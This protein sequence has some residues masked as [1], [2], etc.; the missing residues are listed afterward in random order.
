MT[1]QKKNIFL[2]SA[3]VFLFFNRIGLP[4]G[5]LYTT[6]LAPLFLLFLLNSKGIIPYFLFLLVSGVFALAHFSV[7]MVNELAYFRSFLMMQAV[8]VFVI[9]AYYALP[10][11]LER[12]DTFR[13][14]AT[15][16]AVLLLLCII[17]RLVPAVSGWVW[18]TVPI[19]PG[20]PVVPRLKMFTYEASYY[21]LIITPVLLYYLLRS[22]TGK[23]KPGLLWG[24]LV[25]SLIL[26]FSMGVMACVVISL[27]L[28][29][30][31]HRKR[32]SLAIPVKWLPAGLTAAGCLLAL[33]YFFYPNNPLF[34]RLHNIWAGQDTSARGRTYEAF[35]IAW[36]VAKMKSLYLGI[37]L[38]QLKEL[39]REYIIQYY[40]Y[41]HI[42]ETI[43][44]PNAVAET[45]NIYGVEGL[46]LRFGCI[47]YLFLVTRVWTNS[48][49]L[50]IFLF[51]FIYQFTGSFISNTAEYIIWA[52]AFC[53]GILK[54]FDINR[55]TT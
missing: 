24:T 26:S 51:I 12:A 31:L 40:H 43:R 37:G 38:G 2:V 25:L 33:L 9:T 11:Y 14:M 16:N 28:T 10:V 54:D 49:R 6:L 27:L 21:S 29:A 15:I 4:D 34:M 30:I 55:Q 7:G 48:Y 47:I 35:S 1:D 42:P 36:E 18:Y 44:I 53:P 20:I 41:A 5:L 46:L 19:S 8:A 13:I 3:A 45:L 50:A 22:V 39:G 52:L 32:I 17:A 23:T